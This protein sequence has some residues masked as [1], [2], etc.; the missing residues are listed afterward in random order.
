M[1]NR[2]IKE[3][4]KR[5]PQ[6]DSLTWFEEVVFCRLIVTVDDYGCTDG[7]PVVLKNDLFPTKENITKKAIEDAVSKLVHV[8]LVERYEADGQPYLFLPTWEKHQRIRN[9]QRKYPIPPYLSLTADCGHLPADCP[10][11]SESESESESN[12]NPMMADTHVHEVRE[13]MAFWEEIS[14]SPVSRMLEQE[15]VAKVCAG[16]DTEL[17]QEALKLSRGKSSPG[18]YFEKLLQN[19]RRDGVKDYGGYCARYGTQN[20]S[21]GTKGEGWN[22]LE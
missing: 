19:W 18:K 11:K 14:G 20:D 3:S 15:I 2:V 8:G 16:Y 7:R 5:S 12:P 4:I 10:P 6:I 21:T 13:M 17:L 9:K 1:A 22:R